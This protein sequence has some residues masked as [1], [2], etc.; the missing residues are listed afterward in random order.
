MEIYEYDV[1]EEIFLSICGL[2]RSAEMYI[3]FDSIFNKIRKFF[4]PR[5]IVGSLKIR[6]MVW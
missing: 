5:L 4:G 1:T 3:P 6:G 2:K